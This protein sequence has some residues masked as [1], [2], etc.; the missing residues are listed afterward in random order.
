MV[1]K[2]NV[3]VGWWNWI[4]R[5][6]LLTHNMQQHFHKQHS[7]KPHGAVEY[8]NNQH[9][10]QELRSGEYQE[11]CVW[12]VFEN[13]ERSKSLKLL[14]H[15]E[16]KWLTSIFRKDKMSSEC[17]LPDPAYTSQMSVMVT[18][19]FHWPGNSIT[20][21]TVLHFFIIHYTSHTGRE[22]GTAHLHLCPQCAHQCWSMLVCFGEIISWICGAA[23]GTVGTS[24][25]S[26]QGA[27]CRDMLRVQ[28]NHLGSL[29]SSAAWLQWHVSLR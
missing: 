5:F 8:K 28:K 14:P 21:Q 10:Q 29:P 11:A 1:T 4:R 20:L 6:F 25:P 17:L 12:N 15:E 7:M 18:A 22:I 16:L 13:S 24:C 19:L 23:C 9:K 26:F 27:C 3:L 2:V